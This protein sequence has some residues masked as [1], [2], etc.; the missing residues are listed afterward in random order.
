MTMSR[1]ENMLNVQ[2]SSNNK[3]FAAAEKKNRLI[4]KINVQYVWIFSFEHAGAWFGLAWLGLESSCLWWH[5]SREQKPENGKKEREN[6]Y[7]YFGAHSTQNTQS[8]RNMNSRLQKHWTVSGFTDL[9]WIRKE[10]S[11]R[12][13][14]YIENV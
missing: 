13:I 8:V 2:C 6:C 7:Y 11:K 5:L 10:N 4:N 12:N 3:T 1:I 14:V 9:D